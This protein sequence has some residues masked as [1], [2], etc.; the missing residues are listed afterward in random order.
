MAKAYEPASLKKMHPQMDQLVSLI[1]TH[2]ASFNTPPIGPLGCQIAIK[3]HYEHLG[4]AIQLA[5]HPGRLMSFIVFNSHDEIRLQELARGLPP[6]QGRDPPLCNCM[7]ISIRTREPRFPIAPTRPRVPTIIDTVVMLPKGAD[8]DAWYNLLLDICTAEFKMV[9]NDIDE[10][11]NVVYNDPS[12]MAEAMVCVHY[13]EP[14]RKIFKR[15][16]TCGNEHAP[17]CR[18]VM[19]LGGVLMRR[20]FE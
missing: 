14:G 10:A 16:Q 11:E 5:I 13:G 17:A 8:A 12:R 15:V 3:P 9:S 7:R 19:P 1:E 20:N 6:M 2:R 18:N 4:P